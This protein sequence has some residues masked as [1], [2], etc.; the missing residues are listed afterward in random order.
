MNTSKQLVTRAELFA[1]TEIIIGGIGACLIHYIP[2]NIQ[3][4]KIRRYMYHAVR[5]FRG[6]LF[7]SNL[8]H[9]ESV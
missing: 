8:G 1:S 9:Q 6:S 5:L 7:S 2:V 4:S 3:P